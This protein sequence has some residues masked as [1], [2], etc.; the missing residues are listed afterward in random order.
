MVVVSAGKDNISVRAIAIIAITDVAVAINADGD[1]VVAAVDKDK[2]KDR[3]NNK[4]AD[5]VASSARHSHRSSR[6]VRR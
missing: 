2:V 3:D 1:S 4:A 6:M 5:N